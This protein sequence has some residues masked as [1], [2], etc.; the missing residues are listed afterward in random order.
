VRKMARIV[1]QEGQGEETPVVQIKKTKICA[2]RPD[3]AM[4]GGSLRKPGGLVIR[5]RGSISPS[6]LMPAQVGGGKVR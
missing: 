6:A 4:D 5:G 2:I 1:I 3:I